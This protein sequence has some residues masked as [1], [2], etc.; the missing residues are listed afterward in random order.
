[1]PSC[2]GRFAPSPTGPL[3]EGSLVAA[4]ASWLDARAQHGRWLVRIEDVD[5]PRCV[6]GADQEI[7]RQL[8]ALSLMPDEPPLWQ[9]QRGP[10]YQR[11]LDRLV[12]AGQAYP[13][14][15]TR[16][17]IAEALQAAGRTHER[18]EE[19]VYPGTCRSG[20]HGRPA[21]A[22]LTSAATAPSHS[23]WG[24]TA[25]M[26]SSAMISAACSASET[27]IRTPVRSR[28]WCRLR[29]RNSS[30]ACLR[31]R[32]IETWIFTGALRRLT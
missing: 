10:H 2:I 23:A 28:V 22:W 18:H 26:P 17:D 21:R 1:M 15:C 7:L 12:Q 29:A 32:F 13:C 6:P 31:A 11:A 24:T 8:Q 16:K 25:A 5:G 27:K 4:L 14:A 9:S 19:W 20:L 30:S 3:H